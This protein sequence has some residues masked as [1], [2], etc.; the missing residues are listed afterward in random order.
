MAIQSFES[1]NFENLDVTPMANPNE[2]YKGEGG[3]FSQISVV[4]SFVSLCM[5]VT[6]PCTKSVPTTY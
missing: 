1:P 2:Y 6:R 5:L 3:G 4:M